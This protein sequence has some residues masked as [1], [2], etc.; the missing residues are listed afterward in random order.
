MVDPNPIVASKG[1]QRLKDAGIEVITR[2]EEELCQK[3]L[4]AYSHKMLTG[5]PF[6]TLRFN[7]IISLYYITFSHNLYLKTSVV[8]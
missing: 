1:V 4:E 3:L 2:V 7:Q 8:L 5:N 6:V